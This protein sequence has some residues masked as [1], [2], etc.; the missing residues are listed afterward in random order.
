MGKLVFQVTGA[1]AE[2]ARLGRPKI[3]SA[4]ERKVRRQLAKGTGIPVTRN[5]HRRAHPNEAPKGRL[6]QDVEAL[7][8]AVL[9]LIDRAQEDV[10]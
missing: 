8:T 2:F 7:Q 5:G 1:F 9:G 4:T 10:A 3:D 6:A